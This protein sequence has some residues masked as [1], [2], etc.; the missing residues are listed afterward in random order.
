MR[1]ESSQVKA[2][3]LSRRRMIPPTPMQSSHSSFE[4]E[5][6]YSNMEDQTWSAVD[7]EQFLRERSGIWKGGN[8]KSWNPCWVQMMRTWISDGS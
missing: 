4:E 5:Q 2:P 8:E 6:V 7:E 1:Y 3:P